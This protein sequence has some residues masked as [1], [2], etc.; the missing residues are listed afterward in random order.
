MRLRALWLLPLALF[1]AAA[2]WLWGFGGAGQVARFAAEGQRDVQNAMAGALRSLRAGE[3]GA[4]VSLWTLCFAYGFFHAAGP[5][6]GKL[7]IGG[8]GL[9][10][11][12][13]MLRLSALAV[14]SSLA[15][16][17]TAV[18]LVYASV[19]ALGWSRER[20]QGL[21]EGRM[22][23]LSYALIAGLGLWLVVRGSRALWRNRV[24]PTGP[25][26][27]AEGHHSDHDHVGHGADCAVCGHAHGPSLAEA[28]QVRSL[29]DAVAVIGAVAVRPCT[30]ALFLLILCWRFG[31]DAAGIA[32]AFIMGLGTACVTLVVAL[33][34]VS[35]RE[36]AL[37]RVASGPAVP[38]AMA[39]IEA[40]A[41]A[42]VFAVALQLLLRGI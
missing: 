29:R 39:L 40:L 14:G 41:G 13:P 42:L 26:A 3:P 4:L 2:L 6:H 30:G 21:A 20:M 25:E 31:I 11:R 16:A 7:V 12:V 38:R 24:A 27:A 28:E 22:T 32:G 9:A 23:D 19:L 1:G 10:R 35:L 15:Q 36:S 18:L 17:A 33:A 37:L 8:Y 5:G 34:A